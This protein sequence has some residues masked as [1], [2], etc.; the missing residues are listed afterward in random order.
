MTVLS[1]RHFRVF[2][3]WLT[4]SI[5]YLTTMGEGASQVD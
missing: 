5:F 2:A 1:E 4:L 3:N